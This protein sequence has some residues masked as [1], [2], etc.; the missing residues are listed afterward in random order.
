MVSATTLKPSSF[1]I[2]NIKNWTRGKYNI[3]R[4]VDNMPLSHRSYY[5]SICLWKI[6]YMGKYVFK[7]KFLQGLY[8]F[9]SSKIHT[10]T[11]S[12]PL[13]EAEELTT[14][15]ASKWLLLASSILVSRMAMNTL[16]PQNGFHWPWAS[17]FLEWRWKHW[18][19]S[20]LLYWL[21]W[22]DCLLCIPYQGIQGFRCQE[23][24]TTTFPLNGNQ[25][26]KYA[27]H[28]RDPQDQLHQPCRH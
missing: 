10:T 14:D 5:E 24:A 2:G 26:F 23:A 4:E 12:T 27:G 28:L 17:L 13:Q 21:T 25:L 3:W 6:T 22:S 18:F 8:I 16:Q 1:D 9:L 15:S 20:F 19:S 11:T 7:G